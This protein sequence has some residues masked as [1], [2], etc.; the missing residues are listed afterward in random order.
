MNTHELENHYKERYLGKYVTF[1]RAHGVFLIEDVELL[2]YDW[3][4]LYDDG[5][6]AKEEMHTLQFSCIDT[7]TFFRATRFVSERMALKD[8]TTLC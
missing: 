5:T 3:K 6:C 4:A 8:V 7:Q 1:A 2:T